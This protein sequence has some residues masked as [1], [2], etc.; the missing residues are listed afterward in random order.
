MKTFKYIYKGVFDNYEDCL[1]QT[2]TSFYKSTEYQKKQHKII[3]DVIS[4]LKNHKSILPFYKQHTQYL[5]ILVSLLRSKKK[6]KVLDFGGGWGIGYAN[7]IESLD[8]DVLKKIDYHIYDLPNLCELGKKKF[9]DK[10]K[11][12]DNLK[13]YDDISKI[14]KKYDVI[15]FGSTI[16]YL[17]NPLD[18]VKKLLDKKSKILLF[19]DLYLT[20]SKTFF[21]RQMHYNYQAPHSFINIKKFES[22]FKKKYKIINK[23]Y[24]HTSR[25]NRIGS[26]NMENFKKKYRITNSLNY[27]LKIN[28]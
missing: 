24:A 27:I 11:I 10:M 7:C 15:F 12:K 2:N 21:T 3:R 26:L 1:K 8:K 6:I 16:Q 25:L 22:I 9:K 4:S 20:N 13:Y 5:T 19:I 17:K 18:S 14:D 28:K 23:S